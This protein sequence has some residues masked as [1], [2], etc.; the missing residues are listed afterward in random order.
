MSKSSR[1]AR[2]VR[3]AVITAALAAGTAVAFPAA[4]HA[5]D[6]EHYY[7]E[8][9]GTG[10]TPADAGQGH[11]DTSYD[12]GNKALPP[13]STAVDVCYPHTAGPFI[14]YSGS[15]IE[16][17][18]LQV[19]PDAL[20]AP[21]YDSSVQQGYQ[22]GLQAAEDTHRAH[23][24][25]RITITGYSQGA[26]AADQVLQTI[27]GDTTGIPLSQVDGMLYADPMTP[28]TG[29]TAQFPKGLGVPGFTSPG[30]GPAEFNGIP[31]TRYCIHGDPVCDVSLVNAP[32][33][34][35]LHPKYPA[36][37]NVIAQTLA[38]VGHADGIQWRNPDG[39][40]G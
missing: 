9:G 5:A 16:L 13:G 40:A 8:I 24:D 18:G 26:Q 11:C 32:H 31:V 22:K 36:P 39:N 21:N 23:P 35:D 25:A 30:A 4:A 28:G 38:D 20:T 6:A 33:Y 14:G 19:H 3:T 10:P 2:A 7:I 27:A 12:E 34:F 1:M 29:F 15:L 37:G 17:P